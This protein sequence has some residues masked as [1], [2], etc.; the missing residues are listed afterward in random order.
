M[1]ALSD[2][3]SGD[4]IV[5][6]GG[7]YAVP[8]TREEANTIRISVSGSST[9]N[10][11]IGTEN[12]AEAVFDFGWSDNSKS[13]AGASVSSVGFDI[14]GDYLYFKNITITKA[15]YQGAY[16]SGKHITFDNCV[17]RDNWNSGLEINKGGSYIT[18]LN[19]DAYRNFDSSYKNGG[20]AD[21][22]ASKQTQGPGNRFIGCRAWENSDDGYDTYDSPEFVTF[23]KCW[24]FRNGVNIWKYDGFDG[25]GNGFKVGG[26]FR[27]EKNVLKNCVAFGNV[28]K[29]FDQNNNSGGIT[30]L[31]CIA[32][33]NGINYGF[34]NDVAD[35]EKHIFKNNIA[36]DGLVSIKDANSIQSNNSWNSGFSVG[37]TDFI[38]LDTSLATIRR[39]ADG[40][41]P[42][43]DLFKLNGSSKLIDAGID[44]GL[45]FSGSA[46]DIGAFEVVTI[47]S[48]IV[49]MR[50]SGNRKTCRTL[51]HQWVI[52]LDKSTKQIHYSVYNVNGTRVY[53]GMNSKESEL[54]IDTKNL[55]AGKYLIVCHSNGEKIVFS[56]LK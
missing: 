5:I 22:F 47:D 32:Y 27:I 25:N 10:I 37:K 45:P 48:R 26:N 56:V 44:V 16:V 55:P 6:A 9:A 15:G 35:G 31:N 46:P 17:F 20:M 41:L 33:S 12:G 3:S 54:V 18:V 14:T 7:I 19:C 42:Q 21:G 38:S 50:F 29:G 4:S 39:N 23:E 53:T 36:L 51:A 30:V 43:T 34:V 2:I 1:S 8:S 11:F 13:I 40:S 28:N 49:K 24:A 52:N